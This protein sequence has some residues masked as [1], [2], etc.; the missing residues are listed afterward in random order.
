MRVWLKHHYQNAAVT[1]PDSKRM[2]FSDIADNATSAFQ[3]TIN[4]CALSRA[5]IK[6]FPNT[7]SRK[8]G[9]NR[10]TYVY[11]LEATQQSGQSLEAVMTRNEALQRQVEQLEVKVA[12]LEQK[13]S[14]AQTLDDQMQ[15][16]LHPMMASYHGPNTVGNLENFSLDVVMAEM[17]MN[18]PDVVE[19]LL[20]L[21]KC[22]RFQEGDADGHQKHIASLRSTTALCTLLKGRCVKVLG[23]QLLLSFML[24]ARA[25]S[26]QVVRGGGGT[27]NKNCIMNNSPQVIAVL[28]HA[29]VCISYPTTWKYLRQITAEAMYLDRIRE[30]HWIWA[31]DNLNI[32]QR[33]RHER[34]GTFFPL[35]VL[36]KCSS[37][38]Q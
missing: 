15:E 30:G 12:E 4:P 25:T 22:E 8:T 3:P 10:H 24:I 21:A 1:G 36:E 9:K 32:H 5:I 38:P 14:L 6:E 18:A 23:L 29:G 26:K 17:K 7:V 28:N 11:G 16:L 2:K 20:N 19:L 34:H 31:Y 13:C 37:S 33:V 35:T 27:H